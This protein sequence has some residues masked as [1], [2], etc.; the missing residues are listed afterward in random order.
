MDVKV[1][2][3]LSGQQRVLNK[4]QPLPFRELT[5]VV[6]RNN[7]EKNSSATQTVNITKGRKR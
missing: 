1:P 6:R 4:Y 5:G 2:R 3:P 7:Y